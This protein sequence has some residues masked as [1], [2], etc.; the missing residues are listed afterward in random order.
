MKLTFVIGR[1]INERENHEFQRSS[2]KCVSV[3]QSRHMADSNCFCSKTKPAN[4]FSLTNLSTMA[5][6]AVNG[7]FSSGYKSFLVFR[8]NHQFHLATFS[9]YNMNLSATKMEEEMEEGEIR[10]EETGEFLEKN[11]V[12]LF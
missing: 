12:F 5:E 7:E 11:K 8:G 10:D 3:S 9:D 1:V 4:G 6:F 2:V